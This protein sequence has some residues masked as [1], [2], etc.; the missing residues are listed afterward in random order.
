[1]KIEELFSVRGKIALVTGGSRG[2]GEMIARAY[3]ENGAKVY[4]TAR[5]AAV[6]D[7]LAAELSRFGHCVSIPADLS[8]PAARAE[9]LSR[10]GRQDDAIARPHRG[11]HRAPGRTVLPRVAAQA[12]AVVR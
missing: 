4:I 6:C 2:I 1:M 10:A 5:N 9:W 12:R 8:I 7:G 3:V 11:G